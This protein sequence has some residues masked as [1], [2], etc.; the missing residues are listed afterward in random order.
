MGHSPSPALKTWKRKPPAKGHVVTRV[1]LTLPRARSSSA[2]STLLRP[3]SCL[4][5]YGVSHHSGAGTAGLL[6][7]GVQGVPRHPYR[8]PSGAPSPHRLSDRTLNHTRFLNL[9]RQQVCALSN[10]PGRR[11]PEQ[12]MWGLCRDKTRF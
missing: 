7:S 4:P 11:A 12:R 9:Q 6:R 1:Q 10:K 5:S 3:R 8:L 2:H